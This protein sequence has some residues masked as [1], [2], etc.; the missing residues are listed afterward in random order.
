MDTTRLADA[1]HHHTAAFAKAAAGAHPDARVP[2]CPDWPLRVLVGHVGQA[3]RWS[4]SIVR[5]GPSPVPD[6]FDADPGDPAGW[7][8]WL[9]AGAADLVD[10]VCAGDGPV[11]TF[12]GPGPAT[13]WLRRMLNDTIVHHADAA[14]RAFSVS[15]D[16][17]EDAITDWLELLAHPVTRTLKP[18]VAELHGTGQTLRLLPADAEGWHVTRT[19]DGIEWTRGTAPADATL[20]GPLTDLLLVFTRRRPAD[21]VTITGDRGLVEHWLAHSAA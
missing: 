8:G 7:P 20:A 14:G 18:D 10:A 1:L 12:F 11:W 17:A 3:H 5:S 16:L 19:P 2:T 13:F 9:Q 6:P 15:P 21:D 4:A